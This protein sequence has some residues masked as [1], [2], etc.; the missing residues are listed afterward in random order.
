[1][2]KKINIRQS[3]EENEIEDTE[4]QLV[5]NEVFLKKFNHSIDLVRKVLNSNVELWMSI[6]KLQDDIDELQKQCK[7]MQIENESLWLWMTPDNLDY[8]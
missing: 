1:M 8:Y 5:Q 3:D 7:G 2:G 4:T 6:L